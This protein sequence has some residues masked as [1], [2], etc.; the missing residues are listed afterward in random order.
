MKRDFT[1]NAKN[2]LLGL[3]K[4]VDDEDWC[5]F[6]D[7][8]G[9]RWLDLSAWCGNLDVKDYVDNITSYH[10]KVIDK[11]NTTAEEIEKIFTDVHNV[12]T[13][14]SSRFTALLLNLQGYN[15]SLRSLAKTI[16]PSFG[17]FNPN[18]VGPKL[19]EEIQQYL[20]E[21][22]LLD[23]IAG[24]GL[25][26][27]DVDNMNPEIM[28]KL[29]EGYVEVLTKDRPNVNVGQT[30]EIPI[31]PGTCIYYKTGTTVKGNTDITINSTINDQRLDF[32]GFSYK[33]KLD[34]KGRN[35]I[36][37]G[38]DGSMAKSTSITIGNTSYTITAGAKVWSRTTYL[39][40]SISTKIEG[41]SVSSAVGIKQ[42][43]QSNWKSLPVP[44]TVE[45]PYISQIPDIDW[46]EVGKKV[47]IGV[48]T[49]VVIGAVVY[50]F[51]PSGGTSAGLATSIIPMLEK[52]K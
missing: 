15:K 11:N 24:D 25:N 23:K 1:E 32:K 38:T 36:S 10:K 44:V 26:D 31:G 52:I 27:E 40:N 51:V 21:S 3:V 8:F 22:G 49:I 48:G 14:Y 39:E 16:H 42:T 12:N 45:S 18:Y 5:G 4:E 17:S 19:K 6:T 43:G 28:Q 13:N 47:A 20:D 7:W 35:N 41:G 34:D 46:E 2:E 50:T 37:F 33:V 30:L 29:L 9:D